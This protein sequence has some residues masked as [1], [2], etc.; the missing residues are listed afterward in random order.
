MFMEILNLAFMML[1]LFT[2]LRTTKQGDTLILL[3]VST[4]IHLYTYVCVC[5]V[6]ALASLV[7]QNIYNFLWL[8]NVTVLG[9]GL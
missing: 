8:A 1:Y 9:P 3:Y 7:L 2:N 5:I 4:A 6:C